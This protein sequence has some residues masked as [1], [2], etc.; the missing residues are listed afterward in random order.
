LRPYAF[1]STFE[2][3]GDL[4]A[5]VDASL[6]DEDQANINELFADWIGENP[7]DRVVVGLLANWRWSLN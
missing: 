2:F 5:R 4:E 6:V 7:D 1:Q 3:V